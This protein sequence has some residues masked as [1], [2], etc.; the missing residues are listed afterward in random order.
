MVNKQKQYKR[1]YKL[2]SQRTHALRIGFSFVNLTQASH[3]GRGNL[4]WDYFHQTGLEVSLCGILLVGGWCGRAQPTSSSLTSLNDWLWS[5]LVS[6]TN[7]FLSK[8]FLIMVFF[9]REQI[10]THPNRWTDHHTKT[11]QETGAITPTNAH[12]NSL[13][14]TETNKQRWWASSITG[15]SVHSYFKKLQRSCRGLIQVRNLIQD[16]EKELKS[17][18]FGG[19]NLQGKKYI[20]IYQWAWPNFQKV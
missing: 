2:T 7:P 13:S 5:E 11:S 1:R 17:V 20:Y 10:R 4:S 15:K 8:L 19:K 3:L 16:M 6:Q 9:N 12:T 14:T 18:F